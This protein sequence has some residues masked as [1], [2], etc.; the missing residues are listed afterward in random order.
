MNHYKINFQLLENHGYSLHDIQSM[1]PWERE[2]Y[3][4][5]LMEDIQ[6]KQERLAQQG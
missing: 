4:A 2:V 6:I 5:L 1:I 3:L